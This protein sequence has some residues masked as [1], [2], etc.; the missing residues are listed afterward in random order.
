MKKLL[1]L[2]TALFI[3]TLVGFGQSK[4]T[5]GTAATTPTTATSTVKKDTA[6]IV[7][8]DTSSAAMATKKDVVTVDSVFARYFKATGGVALWDSME[9]YTM[10]RSYRS[11]SSADYDAEIF[12][13]MADQA[14]SKSKIILKRNFIYGVK[15]NDGWLKIPLGSYDKVTKYQ[16]K[17]LSQPEQE[18]MRLEMYDLLVPFIDYK[19]RGLVATLVGTEKMDSTNVYQVEL[20][21]KAVKYNLFFDVK[22]GLL[23]RERETSGTEII[24][25]DFGK[26]VK[27]KFGIL[28]PSALISTSSKDKTKVAI[29]SELMVNEKINPELFKR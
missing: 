12:V 2:S 3:S 25:T 23:L 29:T 11:N 1:A 17:D 24:T 10:K 5:T 21:N 28:Y 18:N 8:K 27:S 19:D 6:T 9:T 13:S 26:Y 15:G 14:M 16:V 4:P 22:T 7:K 20:Q